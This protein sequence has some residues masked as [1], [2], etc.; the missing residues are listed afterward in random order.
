MPQQKLTIVP[1]T[2]HP[3]TKHSLSSTSSKD[4]SISICTIK[5]ANAEIS[6][7]GGVGE[8]VIQ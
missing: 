4:P 1:V 3:D 6:F 2:L 8:H 7:Y 5:T